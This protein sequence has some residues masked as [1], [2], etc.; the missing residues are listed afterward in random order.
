MN[1]KFKTLLFLAVLLVLLMIY[2][3]FDPGAHLWFP[4]CA[5]YQL[6]GLECPTCGSQRAVYALLHGS[7]GEALRLNPFIII[8]IPYGLALLIIWIFKTDFTQKMRSILL[9]RYVVYA[10]CVMFIDW[11]IIRNLI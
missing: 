2:H 1:N 4:K 8:S 9:H 3:F 10:Y 7:V 6:T 11:W 5:F